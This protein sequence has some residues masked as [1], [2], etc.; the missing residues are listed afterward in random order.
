MRIDVYSRKQVL[1]LEPS[2]SVALIS[3]TCP[4][5]LAPLK[6]G[7][8]DVLRLEFDDIVSKEEIMFDGLTPMSLDQADE[9]H[10]F[11]AA[12]RDR[13]FAVH[14]DAGV[15]RSVAVGVFLRD[16][17]DGELTT[18]NINTLTAANSLVLRQLNFKMWTEH[19][20]GI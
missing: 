19:F 16:T 17:L 12:N 11:V 10:A 14:C 13:D 3:I 15:S 7:W 5:D 18:H 6:E 4:N 20:N 8:G 9:V 1:A 2:R